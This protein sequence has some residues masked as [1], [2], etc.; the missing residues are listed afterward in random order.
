MLCFKERVE[1]RDF[2]LFSLYLLGLGSNFVAFLFLSF[3][4]NI[5]RARFLRAQRA[6]ACVVVLFVVR[7]LF[8]DVCLYISKRERERERNWMSFDVCLGERPRE[9][10]KREK[11]SSSHK[12]AEKHRQKT[13]ATEER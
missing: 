1:R 12:T 6:R 3:K 10:E 4:R 8:S 13:K 2:F 9:R 7:V 5:T 11:R